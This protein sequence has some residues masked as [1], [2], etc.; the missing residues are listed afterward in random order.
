[1]RSKTS[2]TS[3][4]NVVTI[5]GARSGDTPS[6]LVPFP[7]PCL[8]LFLSDP[9][10]AQRGSV[11]TRLSGTFGNSLILGVVECLIVQKTTSV[12]RDSYSIRV[13]KCILR[14]CFSWRVR[15]WLAWRFVPPIQLLC[16][17]FDVKYSAVKRREGQAK[18][19]HTLKKI[20]WIFHYWQRV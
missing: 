7:V 4:N 15:L 19:A 5:S 2:I 10:F 12:C 6:L 8:T 17:R 18:S 9:F 16:A 14:Q 3:Q 20:C 1:M 13:R 11:L